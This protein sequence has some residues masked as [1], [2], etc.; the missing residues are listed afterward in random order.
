MKTD[1]YSG[2]TLPYTE[3]TEAVRTKYGDTDNIEIETA[4]QTFALV[5]FVN[6]PATKIG[7]HNA[8]RVVA[9]INY[10]DE[11]GNNI[12]GHEVKGK[13]SQNPEPSRIIVPQPAFIPAETDIPINGDERTLCIALKNRNEPEWYAFGINSYSNSILLK[14]P[15]MKLVAGT[16]KVEINLSGVYLD[17]IRFCFRLENPGQDENI[18]ITRIDC[19]EEKPTSEK[20]N[21]SSV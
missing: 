18:T 5:D 17:E 20:G 19:E 16:I 14:Q 3:Y 10:Y 4:R 2:G 8:E 1:R 21:L 13:W 12:L 9:R 15:E 6:N 11:K 7:A